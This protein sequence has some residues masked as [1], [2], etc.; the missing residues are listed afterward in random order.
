MH[1]LSNPIQDGGQWDMWVNLVNKYGVVP[2]SEMPESYSSSNS[3][4]MNR[5]ITRKLRENAKILRESL[6]KGATEDEVL[7]Q[8]TL[9]LQDIYKMLTIHLGTPPSTFN[10]QSR[11]K[12]YFFYCWPIGL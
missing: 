10:W 8:K 2:Q 1:L 5:M 6:N 3:R 9:M 11:D 4:Y 7:D 12:F